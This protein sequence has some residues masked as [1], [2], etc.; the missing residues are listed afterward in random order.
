MKTKFVIK[1]LEDLKASSQR[2]ISEDDSKIWNEIWRKDMEALKIA[3]KTIKRHVELVKEVTQLKKEVMFYAKEL[4]NSERANKNNKAALTDAVQEKLH[5][6]AKVNELER[7][8]QITEE[9]NRFKPM[10]VQGEH[11]VYSLDSNGVQIVSSG[12]EVNKK[13]VREQGIIIELWK[14][15]YGK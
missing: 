13:F 10:M 1:Q 4:V 11:S 9:I 5:L 12:V 15:H 8:Y 2:F 7:R 14:L 3:I 6:L